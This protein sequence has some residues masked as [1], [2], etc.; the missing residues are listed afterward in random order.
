[1]PTISISLPIEWLWEIDS[2]V[3]E[4]K[5]KTPLAKI[6]RNMVIRHYIE[7]GM[8]YSSLLEQ[9]RELRLVELEGETENSNDS[10]L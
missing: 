8:E 3:K 2:A 6:S 7:R 10:A 1:M 5:Q 4:Q 9:G